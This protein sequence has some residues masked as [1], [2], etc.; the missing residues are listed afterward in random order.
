MADNINIEKMKQALAITE[1]MFK[2]EKHIT[3]MKKMQ[4]DAWNGISNAIFQI[5]G[6]DWFKKVPKTT[7]EL[8]KQN[9]EIRKIDDQLKVVG[10]NLNKKLAEALPGIQKSAQ[11]AANAFKRNFQIVAEEFDKIGLSPEMKEPFKDV[12]SGMNDVVKRSGEWNEVLE[13]IPNEIRDSKDA[14]ALLKADFD[15]QIQ[16]RNEGHKTYTDDLEFINGITDKYEKQRVLTAL[17]EGR[18]DE[19]IKSQGYNA[20]AILGTSRQITNAIGEEAVAMIAFKEQADETKKILGETHTT[21]LS[22]GKGL[23][24]WAMNITK[25]IVPRVLEFDKSIHDAQKTTGIMFTENAAKMTTLVRQTSEFGMS[26]QDTVG[27]M[28][29]LG[30][31]LPSV[32][33]HLLAKAADDLKAVQL[34]T[35][36]SSENLT[37]ITVEMLRFGQ[38]S[39]DVKLSMEQA[40]VYAKQFGIS[41]KQVLDGM[42]RNITKMRQMGF[43]EGE[44]SLIKMVATAERLRMNVDE[45]FD[46]AKRARQIEGAMEMAAELQLAGGSFANINPMDLLSAA[47][48][49]P[50]ELQ[51]ILTQMGGDIGSFDKETGKYKF[52]PVD[53]DRLQI[54]ADATGQSMDSIQNMIAKNA[55]DNKKLLMF[56]SDMFSID[57]LDPDSVKNQI[58]DAI[59]IGEDGQLQI[60]EGNIFG[61]KSLDE[62]KKMTKED[63]GD[64]L[65]QVEEEAKNLEKQAKQN[66][67]FQDA[68]TA[69]KDALLNIFTYLQ[70]VVTG[71]TWIFQTIAKLLNALGPGAKWVV[72]ILAL[73]LMMPKL[74]AVLGKAA[75]SFNPS[76]WGK[77]FQSGGIKGAMDNVVAKKPS[78]PTTTGDGLTDVSKT[79]TPAK[80]QGDGFKSLASGLKSMSGAKVMWGIA[81]VALA[82]PALVLLL[83]GIPTLLAMGLVGTMGKSVEM[84]FRAMGKGISALGQYKGVQKGALAMFLIGASLIPFA[85]AATLFSGIEW[86]TLLKAGAAILGLVVILAIVGA[87]VGTG[88]GMGILLGAVAL[89]AISV[90]LAVTAGGLLLFGLAMQELASVDWGSFDGV[91]LS[92]AK[93]AGGL[94][95]FSL[96]GLMFLNPVMLI[97]MMLMISTLSAVSSILIPLSQALDLGGKGLDL[98]ASGVL[99]LSDSLSKLDFAKLQELK[100]FSQA[101]ASASFGGQAQSAV[102]ALVDAIGKLGSEK[103]TSGNGTKTLVVQLK[104]PNGRIIQEEIIKDIDKVS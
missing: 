29:E 69:M 17:A 71:I 46:T 77:I 58:S 41:T 81:N 37:T 11:E 91:G 19:Y 9:A 43:V 6:S 104:M 50:L 13:N 95:L 31:A 5:S 60:K 2:Q 23:K 14:L 35:G 4:N 8:L 20:L 39:E 89:I 55:E 28:S 33:F 98:M 70:P 99:K 10:N 74:I 102:A 24:S 61:A 48:Q 26:I 44:Q 16:I 93:L 36:V 22:I 100:G 90:A 67:G 82:A 7:E 72:G 85:V 75:F 63:M 65:K 57:G 86:G 25:D 68:M 45:I 27:F 94:A 66:Q 76:N 30:K 64:R 79:K 38:S 42:S 80:G 103:S 83:A 18:I 56:P 92:L 40:N 34:A 84:G 96:A 87:I 1:S 21:V 78:L 54:V 12:L 97:G 3:E 51:K 47:R 101:M 62:L 15:E 53:V 52:D 59:E 73:S 32:D 88:T 49:G